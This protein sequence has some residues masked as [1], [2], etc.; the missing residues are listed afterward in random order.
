MLDGTQVLIV[1]DEPVIAIEIAEIVQ[2]AN[3]DVVGPAHSVGEARN[4][5]RSRP[6]DVALLDINLPDGQITPIVEA[7]RAQHVPTII[8]TGGE[9]PATVKA[10]HPD[11]RVLQKP[12]L[13]A[14]L[15]AEI[16]K[17]RK[18]DHAAMPSRTPSRD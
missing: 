10:R 6:I 14:R 18:S 12:A 7:L 4:L 17:A 9:L 2:E 11:L 13:P 5:I 1:E 3:G 16:W 8:Y 15:V